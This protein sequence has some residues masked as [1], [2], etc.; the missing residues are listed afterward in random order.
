ML[1]RN[2]FQC[3][4][5]QAKEPAFKEYQKQVLKNSK[6]LVAGLLK[7]DYL[8]I[9]GNLFAF[10]FLLYLFHRIQGLVLTAATIQKLFVFAGGTDNHLCLVD[11]KPKGID[12][13][14]VERICELAA[15]TVNKNSVPGDKSALV[16]GGLRLG[17]L[18]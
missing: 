18:Y 11:L 14:R 2:L 12:G 4:I 5:L 7:R 13:A 17:K 10:F 3:T 16:P 1:W 9:S 6:A 8:V 15:I